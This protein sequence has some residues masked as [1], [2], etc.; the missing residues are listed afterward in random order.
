M[1]KNTANVIPLANAE[2][3]QDTRAIKKCRWTGQGDHVVAAFNL[4]FNSK[5]LFR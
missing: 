2:K 3:A 5:G 4:F 1:S